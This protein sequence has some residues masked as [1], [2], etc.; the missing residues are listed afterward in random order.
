MSRIPVIAPAVASGISFR[1]PASGG[2]AALAGDRLAA[3]ARAILV[4]LGLMVFSLSGFG[5]GD[6]P[7]ASPAAGAEEAKAQETLRAYLQLQEQLHATELTLERNRKAAEEAAAETARGFEARLDEIQQTLMRQ[8]A[9]ELVALQSANRAML[10]VAGSFAALGLLAMAFIACF[11]WRAINRLAEFS[12]AWPAVPA[13]GPRA[14]RAA[15]EAGEARVVAEDPVG[16][17]S[18]RLLG[19]LERLEQRI[20]Q[21]EHSSPPPLPDGGA[22]APHA[23][24]APLQPNGAQPAPEAAQI[25]LLLGRGQSLL[26]LGQAAEALGCFEQALAL[27]PNHAEALVRKGVA[28]ERLQKPDEAIACYDQAIAADAS[29]TVAYLYKGGL[30]NRLERFNEAL[31]CYEQALRT[32]ENRQR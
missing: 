30:F 19:A 32:Q 11:Q 12:A 22:P 18:Q 25:T 17:S 3:W 26:N 21:L 14:S 28:L 5:A 4:S 27:E 15:L 8:R 20:R 13:L 31:A 29:L 6:D 16:Q 1:R 10:F 9:Q 2:G 7:P 24:P 23:A